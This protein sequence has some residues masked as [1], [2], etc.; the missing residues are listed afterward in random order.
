M[1]AQSI[2]QTLQQPTPFEIEFKAAIAKAQR[3]F[4]NDSNSVVKIAAGFYIMVDKNGMWEV[5]SP[6]E[7]HEDTWQADFFEKNGSTEW[8]G[9]GYKT[10]PDDRQ[11]FGKLNDFR[12]WIS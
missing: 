11:N 12:E 6:R 4:E 2:N 8:G 9:Y 7:G 10:T 1:N 3:N 5:A